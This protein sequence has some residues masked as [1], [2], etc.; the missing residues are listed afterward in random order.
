MSSEEWIR[1]CLPLPRRNL[2]AFNEPLAE[3]PLVLE[4]VY[5][6][7]SSETPLQ[8]ASLVG[9]TNFAKEIIRRRPEFAIELNKDGFSPIH[10]ASANEYV[11]IV[12]ELLMIQ[13]GC[14]CS[15]CVAEVTFRSLTA[16]HLAVKNNQF[17][18]LK[19]LVQG[20]IGG[21]LLNA[22][23]SNGNTVLHLAITLKQHQAVKFLLSNQTVNEEVEVNAKN[24][25]NF[26]LGCL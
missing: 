4:R 16:L 17:E 3:D 2:D 9:R 8:I 14:N 5:F 15:D 1:G 18:A 21:Q 23:D 10:M 12:E 20:H 25:S 7:S 13:G 11:E 22:K 26:S 19:V 6:R 24:A